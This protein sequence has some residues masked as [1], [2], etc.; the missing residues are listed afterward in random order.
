M[1]E[2][3]YM[4]PRQAAVLGCPPKQTS[5]LNVPEAWV[6][7]QLRRLIAPFAEA[8]SGTPNVGRELDVI[9]STLFELVKAED[10]QAERFPNTF[11]CG[12]CGRFTTVTNLSLTPTCTSHGPSRQFTQPEIPD[13]GHLAQLPVPQCANNDRGHMALMNTKSLSTGVWY[14]Q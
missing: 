8:V 3:P 12:A 13:C 4:W 10:L 14:W 5:A 7:P 11:H 9:N 1:P 6:K 2:Q